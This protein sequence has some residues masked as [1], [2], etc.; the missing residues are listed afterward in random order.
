MIEPLNSAA[1]CVWMNT[2]S[3]G[4]SRSRLSSADLAWRLASTDQLRR[5]GM[6]PMSA[7]L[8]G[9]AI[10]MIVDRTESEL[11][12][13][14]RLML[15]AC[16]TCPNVCSSTKT[17]SDNAPRLLCRFREQPRHHVQQAERCADE[18][19][20][21]IALELQVGIRNEEFAHDRG[22]DHGYQCKDESVSLNVQG[23]A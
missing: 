4:P 8:R 7:L 23:T 1:T 20:V 16:A 10:G 3:T 2:A 9:G 15:R 12:S 11:A 6:R 19:H 21:A 14:A 18:D 17:R 22:A 13:S 5:P